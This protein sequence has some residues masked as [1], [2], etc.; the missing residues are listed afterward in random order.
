MSPRQP[1]RRSVP[2]LVFERTVANHPASSWS[3]A[4]TLSLLPS[5]T[6]ASE[7]SRAL[8]DA[9]ELRRRA[10]LLR[11][12]G[13]SAAADQLEQRQLNPI[14]QDL[15]NGGQATGEQLE[16]L[17]Q[18]E[19]TRVRDAALLAELL[20][21]LLH[22]MLERRTEAVTP[23]QASNAARLQP[24]S[25]RRRAAPDSIAGFIDDMLTQRAAPRR[26]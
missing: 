4:A 21:P 15:L 17:F 23:A 1:T 19:E 26:G 12:Q 20:V 7:H 6:V 24:A 5:S 16:A 8:H 2:D 3:S 18:A 25:A 11:Q 22:S 9:R 10:C 13:E 14:V